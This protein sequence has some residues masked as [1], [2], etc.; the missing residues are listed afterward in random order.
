MKTAGKN[1]MG[2]LPMNHDDDDV[3]KS[4]AVERKGRQLVHL[5]DVVVFHSRK[6]G[7]GEV[8]S[9]ACECE[10]RKGGGVFEGWWHVLTVLA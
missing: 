3:G 7:G 4:S 2:F 5:S 6:G 10:A 1:F 8:Y 9:I